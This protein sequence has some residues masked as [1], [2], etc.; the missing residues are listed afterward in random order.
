[1]TNIS[2]MAEVNTNKR[3]HKKLLELACALKGISVPTSNTTTV[4][5]LKC[6]SERPK[7]AKN[8]VP[9]W[10]FAAVKR[11]CFVAARHAPLAALAP[12]NDKCGCSTKWL[13]ESLLH[14]NQHLSAKKLKNFLKPT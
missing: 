1:M 9:G 10:Q 5:P 7:G 11:D 12:R 3:E 4:L 2:T 13:A 14:K 8:L 6:H